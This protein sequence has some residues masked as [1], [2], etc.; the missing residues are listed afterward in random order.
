MG[1]NLFIH[2]GIEK[3]ATT[4]LQN[5]LYSKHSQI[6]YLGRPYADPEFG[7]LIEAIYLN[8]SLTFGYHHWR[9]IADKVVKMQSKGKIVGLSEEFLASWITHDCGLVANRLRELFGPSKIVITIRRQ[10]DLLPSLYM[11]TIKMRPFQSFDDWLCAGLDPAH[12]FTF[13]LYDFK[14]LADY[15]INLFGRENVGL[16]LFEEFVENKPWFIAK[17][18]EFL[19][20]DAIEAQ[21]LLEGKHENPRKGQRL[22]LY[23]AF[24][25][26]LFPAVAFSAYIPNALNQAVQ[27]FLH[28]GNPAR[29]YLSDNARE[30]IEK[31]FGESNAYLANSYHLPLAKY[32]YPLPVKK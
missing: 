21:R 13:H 1:R 8:G 12:G 11:D 23:K 3:T 31:A 9:E 27:R 25:S 30:A 28:G 20:I 26:K 15:Y 22:V 10:T 6:I 17:M 16:F 2:I 7:K 5:H 32:G 14:A 29:I 18:S 24:R 19:G 4:T